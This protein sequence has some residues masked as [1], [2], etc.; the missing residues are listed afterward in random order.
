[1][2]DSPFLFVG[3]GNPGDTYDKTRHN[4]G[5][6][7]L[8]EF[9]RR[10]NASV[11]KSKM[12]GRFCAFRCHGSPVMLLQ[13]QTYMNRSGECV[14][15]FVDYYKVETENILILHDDID[16]PFGRIKAV[17]GGGAGGHNGIKSI[18]NHLGTNKL[19]RLK[20]GVGRPSAA[21]GNENQPVD[22][23]VLSKFTVT[24]QQEL[25]EQADLVERAIE[26]F[27]RQGISACMNAINGLTGAPRG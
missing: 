23:Y 15:R 6:V 21:N 24:E 12:Q 4:I 7:M 3:L 11:N 14:R 13:P 17:A 18:I 10:H 27:I 16:L 5:F 2:A 20:I 26:V 1:M 9:A 19:P 8:D 25:D 22:K